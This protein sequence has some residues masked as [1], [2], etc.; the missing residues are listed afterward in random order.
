[1][2]NARLA[3]GWTPGTGLAR[4]SVHA[5]IREI[6]IHFSQAKQ[7]QGQE[8]RILEYDRDINGA[9]EAVPRGTARCSGG[10][11][12]AEQH[13]PA[14]DAVRA[15]GAELETHRRYGLRGPPRSERWSRCSDRGCSTLFDGAT[16][17]RDVARAFA[18]LKRLNFDGGC[19]SSTATTSRPPCQMSETSWRAGPRK[20]EAF[21]I[22]QFCPARG[23]V[24]TTP[25]RNSVPGTTSPT[26]WHRRRRRRRA[27]SGGNGVGIGGD[28]VAM[29][30]ATEPRLSPGGSTTRHPIGS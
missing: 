25:F 29:H 22:E 27:N 20:A 28:G 13:S 8:S 11:R 24:P 9:G 30:H 15:S 6:C 12:G 19:A 18:N 5:G 16:F 26:M 1:M 2:T 3:G 14:R 17:A 10:G 4:N 23:G 21:V 7:D